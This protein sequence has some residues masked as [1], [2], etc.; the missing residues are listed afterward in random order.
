MDMPYTGYA[1]SEVLQWL[2]NRPWRHSSSYEQT[3][4][5]YLLGL[6]DIYACD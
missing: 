5:G 3:A 1:K 6:L 4:N 2:L